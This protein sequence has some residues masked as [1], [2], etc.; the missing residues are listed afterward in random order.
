[1]AVVMKPKIATLRLSHDVARAIESEAA[2]AGVSASQFIREAALARASAAIAARGS[3]DVSLLGAATR[4]TLSPGSVELRQAERTISAFLRTANSQDRETMRAL[5][6]EG[7]QAV[8]HS[9]ERR[10]ARNRND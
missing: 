2:L 1:M 9:R 4:Q 6:A 10:T 7:T 3:G 5:R 8:K